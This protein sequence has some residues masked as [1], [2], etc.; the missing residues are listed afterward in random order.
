MTGREDF[1]RQVVEF[2]YPTLWA[3]RIGKN[4]VMAATFVP[5]DDTHTDVYVRWYHKMP[6]FLRPLMDLYGQISQFIVFRDDLP[7]V[8]SQRPISVDDASSDK[9]VPSDAALVAFRK[10]RRAHQDELQAAH[11]DPDAGIGFPSP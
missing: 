6:R 5:V 7:I 1:E 4:Y 2:V 3:N 8:A 9:L 11:D 10:L